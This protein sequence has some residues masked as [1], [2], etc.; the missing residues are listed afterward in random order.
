[1]VVHPE[2]VDQAHHVQ[3]VGEPM[4]I[5]AIELHAADL[6]RC[7]QSSDVGLRFEDGHG[8]SLLC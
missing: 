3:V 6:E 4:V 2:F 5:E 1:V 7:S 8:D